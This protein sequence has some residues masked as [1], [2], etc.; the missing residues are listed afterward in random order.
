MVRH[1]AVQ[2]AKDDAVRYMANA[3]SASRLHV[4]V[5]DPLLL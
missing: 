2:L 5:D 1:H 4:N 3:P